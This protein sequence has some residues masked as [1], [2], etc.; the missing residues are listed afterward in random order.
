MKREILEKL[1]EWK[2]RDD[3]KPLV[4]TGARQVG[5]TWVLKE[6]GQTQFEKMAY[7]NFEEMKPIRNLFVGDFDMQRIIVTL[8]AASRVSI[9][10]GDTL[11]VLDEIQAAEGGLTA[12]KYFCERMPG[13]HVVAAGSLLGV[14]MHRHTS[15]PVG[16]A[17]GNYK[18]IH[19][20]G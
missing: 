5:K 17:N 8:N 12:L 1:I 16:K 9:T 4:L 19:F 15:Y 2:N 13:L 11:L 20:I 6:L 10:E 18:V 7:V 14:E 3:R